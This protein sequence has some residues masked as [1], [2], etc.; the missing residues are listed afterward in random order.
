M[1]IVLWTR[2]P[3]TSATPK[4][5]NDRH[6]V[7]RTCFTNLLLQIR[8]QTMHS[9]EFS[10]MANF[11]Q[12]YCRSFPTVHSLSVQYSSCDLSP[13]ILIRAIAPKKDKNSKTVLL[14][15]ALSGD[16]TGALVLHHGIHQYIILHHRSRWKSECLETLSKGASLVPRDHSTKKITIEMGRKKIASRISATIA[17]WNCDEMW[18]F[19]LFYHVSI[20]MDHFFSDQ[21]AFGWTLGLPAHISFLLNFLRSLSTASKKVVLIYTMHGIRPSPELWHRPDRGRAAYPNPWRTQESLGL[22]SA[23]NHPPHQRL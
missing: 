9:W 10:G 13:G 2:Q 8:D 22:C 17:G 20:V 1:K 12:N 15:P 5:R 19:A 3:F 4:E 6:S 14:H 11:S 21:L 18:T 23:Q 7:Q 16:H